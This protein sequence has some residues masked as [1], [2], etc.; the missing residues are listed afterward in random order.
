MRNA[1]LIQ[2]DWIEVLRTMPDESA[3]C[4]VTSPPYW[5]L[6]DYGTARWE[7]GDPNCKHGGRVMGN[8]NKGNVREVMDGNRNKCHYCDAIRVD[9]QLGLER[10]PDEYVAKM[11][12]GFREVRRVLRNDGTLWL[13]LG[14]SYALPPTMHGRVKNA[15]MKAKDLVGIPWAVAFALRADG[16]YL[17]QDI[18]WSKP[19]PM[20]ESVRDRCTKA[21]EYIFLLSK[22]ERYWYDGDAI[23]EALAYSSIERLSQPT[24][25]QQEGSGRVPGKTNGNMKAVLPRCY[26]GSTFT[27][28][29]TAAPRANVGQG[30]RNELATRNKRSVWNV[31]TRGYSDAHFATFP[32]EIPETCIKAGTKE[33]DTVLDPFNGAGT[34]G[35]VATRLGR[36]YIGIELNAEYIEMS[37][38]R[39]E[40]DAPLFNTFA[41]AANVLD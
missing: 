4:V 30:D 9:G 18:I 37:Q 38:R 34:T 39:I 21:H 16:W 5:G 14:D 6:R 23:S 3:H 12:E 8:A 28:G 36:N 27:R 35:L 26:N 10:T 13:N 31:T 33:G 22:S 24:L 41:E 40:D 11:V 2:G 20:P 29:K 7:G 17:R 1:R 15:G 19:N 32:P 25:G